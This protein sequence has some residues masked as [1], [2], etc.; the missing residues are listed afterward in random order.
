MKDHTLMWGGNYSEKIRS[1]HRKRFPRIMQISDASTVKMW[2]AVEKIAKG[3]R[4]NVEDA[5]YLFI[6]RLEYLTQ[7]VAK[8]SLR[9]GFDGQFRFPRRK[10]G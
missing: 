6:H 9:K 3:K 7:E 1:L 2:K 5:N 4:P 8:Q 10:N